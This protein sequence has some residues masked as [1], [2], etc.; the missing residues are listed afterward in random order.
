VGSRRME[1]PKDW[2]MSESGQKKDEKGGFSRKC[3]D[4]SNCHVGCETVSGGLSEVGLKSRGVSGCLSLEVF[5][6]F[7]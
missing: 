6:R 2:G 5:G 1:T 3:L 7:P 4:P